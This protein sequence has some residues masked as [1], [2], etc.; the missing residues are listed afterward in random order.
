M[1]TS[2][3]NQTNPS[4]GYVTDEAK[5]QAVVTKDR[6]ADGAFFYSVKTTGVYCLP[7]CPARP[8]LR[9]NVA[10]HETCEEAERAGFR[11]CK[12]CWPRGPRL[13][14]AH[15]ASIAKAC[16]A[17]E[18]AE[19][20][21]TLEALARAAGM[22]AFHFHRV[23][24]KLTGLT[25]KGYAAAHRSQRVRAQLAQNNT[26]TTAIYDA[27]FVSNGRFYAR[28]ADM[29]GMKPKR[30]QRGGAGETIR[31][32][33]GECSLGSIL[34]AASERGVCAIF[35]GDDPGTLAREL[36]DRFSKADL[37]GG[38]AEFE[39]LVAKVIGFVEA[40][41]LGLDLPLDVRGTAFQQRV[42]QALREIPAGLTA[43]YAEIAS[44]LG[45]P[46]AAR[47]VAGACAANAIAVVI[48]CH[49]VVRRSGD[50]CGYRWGVERKRALLEKERP[51]A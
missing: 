17:I 30:Y 11:P 43:S 20:S 40:P 5:W 21:P 48:P 1:N 47:A 23:F 4:A 26:V 13:A 24:K 3:K 25:P 32:A 36:Q 46:K 19:K 9:R 14:Q 37:I 31:F 29:L 28:A 18:A 22:S 35:L 42:W 10:F 49:R 27:G 6:N 45:L 33:I 2:F 16:R 50:L 34:V 44:R 12:R 39:K 7:S 15:A 8:A 41:R 51:A 38:D